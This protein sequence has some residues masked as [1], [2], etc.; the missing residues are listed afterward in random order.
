MEFTN[1][2]SDK[3]CVITMALVI[4]GPEC[5]ELLTLQIATSSDL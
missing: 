1:T 3:F 4:R 2:F 5:S